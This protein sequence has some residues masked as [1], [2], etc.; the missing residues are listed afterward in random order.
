MSLS[1]KEFPITQPLGG[2]TNYEILSQRLDQLQKVV[3]IL[4]STIDYQQKQINIL[5]SA[6]DCWT[7]EEV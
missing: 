3:E 4:G 6:Y 1:D 2:M 5:T 7:K